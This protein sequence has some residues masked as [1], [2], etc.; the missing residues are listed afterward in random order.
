MSPRTERPRS[1]LWT[2]SPQWS[3]TA[4][5]ARRL[6]QASLACVLLACALRSDASLAE[7]SLTPQDRA[8][9]GGFLAF[10]PAPAQPGGLCL[11][12]TGVNVNPDTQAALAARIA[13]D[14]GT[15][16]DTSPELHGTVM[17]MMAA[18]PRNGWGMVGTAPTSI[19]IVSVRILSPG[20]TT[21]PST[22][23][24]DGIAT[25]LQRRAQYNINTINLSLGS[26]E[27]PSSEEYEALSNEIETANNDDVAVVAA[28][29]NDNGGPLDYPAA[30]PT[31]LSVS[32]LDTATGGYCPFANKG[33]GLR[34]IAPGCDL[35]GADPLTGTEKYDYWQGSSEASVITAAALT[36]MRAYNPN[37]SVQA[38]EN[39]LTSA[40]TGVL[41]IAASF[42]LA[43]LGQ[44]VAQGEAAEPS[45]PTPESSPTVSTIASPGTP[46]TD[47][48]NAWS[49]GTLPAPRV[50]IE[51]RHTILLL[52]LKGRPNDAR[53][54]VRL[55]GGRRGPTGRLRLL[56]AFTTTTSQTVLQLPATGAREI[57]LRYID[58]YD[59]TRASRWTIVTLDVKHTT[60]TP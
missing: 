52:I 53:T 19:K 24:T 36:A 43:G 49:P 32:A 14:N 16:D 56:R 22:Y 15:G 42:R 46:A 2:G 8:D 13:I 41:D 5:L 54:Q 23:Y 3:R 33:T 44:I 58:P 34:L 21:F 11:V 18:A 17:A 1:P 45:T 57:K 25:C 29:G 40:H 20:Q 50:K 27:T 60:R 51:R 47:P 48:D 6:G 4:A 37:L 9:D 38:A 28:A 30:Y 39:D 10:S 55:L 35:L 12:D 7:T 26:Q 59:I 31:V